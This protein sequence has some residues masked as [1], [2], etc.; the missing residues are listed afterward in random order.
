MSIVSARAEAMGLYRPE[1]MRIPRGNSRNNDPLS[2]ITRDR[3]YQK[4]DCLSYEVETRR[5]TR[6]EV[7]LLL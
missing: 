5:Q 3:D 4:T 6:A 2:V 7:G 1:P